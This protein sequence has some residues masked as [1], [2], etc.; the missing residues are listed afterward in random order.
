[1]HVDRCECIEMT[2]E[3]GRQAVRT[4][5][6]RQPLATL[7]ECIKRTIDGCM[8]AFVMLDM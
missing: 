8:Y 3:A 4:R 5:W 1:M 7:Y 2:E 6:R